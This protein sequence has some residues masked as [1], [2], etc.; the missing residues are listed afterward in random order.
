V[1]IKVSEQLLDMVIHEKDQCEILFAIDKENLFTIDPVT[2]ESNCI[3]TLDFRHT[4]LTALAG[5]YSSS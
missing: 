5:R 2:H 4:E 3:L 1:R